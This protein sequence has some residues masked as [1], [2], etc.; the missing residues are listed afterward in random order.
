MKHYTSKR[1]HRVL[2]LM[3]SLVLLLGASPVLAAGGSG[4]D[5][6]YLMA[7]Q[8]ALHGLS[9]DGFP[10]ALA[11]TGFTKPEGA[12]YGSPDNCPKGTLSLSAVTGD[13]PQAAEAQ[14]PAGTYTV[15]F[16]DKYGGYTVGGITLDSAAQ[17]EK[18]FSV[19][20]AAGEETTLSYTLSEEAQGEADS[21][22]PFVTKISLTHGG[23]TVE[24]TGDD[25]APALENVKVG[26]AVTVKYEFLIRNPYQQGFRGDPDPENVPAYPVTIPEK[27]FSYDLSAQEIE[28]YDAS[29]Q[30][31]AILYLDAEHAKASIKFTQTI[32][33]LTASI[34]GWF[35][36]EGN[37]AA[38]EGGGSGELEFSVAGKPV[39]VIVSPEGPDKQ[40]A[41]RTD[42]SGATVNDQGMI[43]WTYTVAPAEGA[44]GFPAGLVM[45]DQ[46]TLGDTAQEIHELRRLE[47]VK[48][49]NQDGEVLTLSEVGDYTLTKGS[50]VGG[51]TV[52]LKK[53]FPEGKSL[54][55]AFTSNLSEAGYKALYGNAKNPAAKDVTVKNTVTSYNYNAEQDTPARDWGTAKAQVTHSANVFTKARIGTAHDSGGQKVLTWRLYVNRNFMQMPA[56]ATITDT[57]PEGLTYLPG[58]LKT[59]LFK[60]N[61]TGSLTELKNYD[62]VVTGDYLAE[63]D[64]LAFTLTQG[65]DR[66]LAIE[67][68]TALPEN[69]NDKQTFTNEASL[70]FW[71][72][73]VN[74]SAGS[75]EMT[76]NIVRKASV[77]LLVPIR[78]A[79]WDVYFGQTA[80]TSTLRDTFGPNQALIAGVPAL[81]EQYRDDAPVGD[82]GKTFSEF[83][84]S[85]Y[86]NTGFKPGDGKNPFAT[87]Y[88][89]RIDGSVQ[90]TKNIPQ[91]EAVALPL[92]A[93]VAVPGENGTTATANYDINSKTL[94]VAFSGPLAGTY[95]LRFWTQM[96]SNI[97]YGPVSNGNQAS[98]DNMTAY[99]PAQGVQNGVTLE[100]GG[101]T[102]TGSASASVSG[103]NANRQFDKLLKSGHGYNQ[104]NHTVTWLL[105]ANHWNLPQ[106]EFKIVD[107]LP[108]GFVLVDENLQPCGDHPEKALTVTADGDLAKGNGVT[109][110]YGKDYTV[111]F[112][113]ANLVLAF[114]GTVY[115]AVDVEVRTKIT[116]EALQQQI[117][118]ALQ[119]A[120]ASAKL[121]WR[122][123]GG[124]SG[125]DPEGVRHATGDWEEQSITVI[126]AS[127]SASYDNKDMISWTVKLNENKVEFPGTNGQ[128]I[129]DQL[130]IGNLPEGVAPSDVAEAPSDVKLKVTGRDNKSETF[131]LGMDSGAGQSWY[132]YDPDTLTIQVHLVTPYGAGQYDTN[133]YTL[134]YSTRIKVPEGLKG[135]NAIS[136]QNGVKW[137]KGGSSA[138]VKNIKIS[139]V[140]A[141]VNW[142]TMGRLTIHKYAAADGNP[143]TPDPAQPL[144][145][146]HFTVYTADGNA[147]AGGGYTGKDGTVSIVLPK[148]DYVVYEDYA[149]RGYLASE[150]SK[151]GIPVTVVPGESTDLNNTVLVANERIRGG[152]NVFKYEKA[153]DGSADTATPLPGAEFGLFPKGAA[154]DAEPLRTATTDATGLAVFPNLAF[155][156]Y[157]VRELKA[158]DGY[159]LDSQAQAQDIRDHNTFYD[160]TFV[161]EPVLGRLVVTKMS[162]KDAAGAQSLLTGAEFELLAADGATVVRAAQAVDA[163]GQVTFSGLRLGSYYLRETKAPEGYDLH[164]GLI[165]VSAVQN[166]QNNTAYYTVT[167]Q[168]T[169]TGGGGGGGGGGGNRPNRPV[170]TPEGMT[171]EEVEQLIEDGYVPLSDAPDLTPEEIIENQIPLAYMPPTAVPA[172][173]VPAATGVPRTG[174][175]APIALLLSMMLGS[176]GGMALL[177]KRR[178]RER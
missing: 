174:D 86:S 154:A 51:F 156:E 72:Y 111:A 11:L 22:D 54:T 20:V 144:S 141:A 63:G 135:V 140:E 106:T 65:I 14:V 83:Y 6:A 131:E 139:N 66:P 80:G 74:S 143:A 7:A 21:L 153:A 18:A 61:V 152:I 167:N 95:R 15:A 59:Y 133:A 5:D 168:L 116:D 64:P 41:G 160:L 35:T 48:V 36:Y 100:T 81:A 129:T 125:T 148:G 27:G 145:G 151:N 92:G 105:K 146:A 173:S 121:T 67:F 128:V 23:K 16:D 137:Y 101:K 79:G 124:Q 68:D 82:T 26:D 150:Q 58:T 4:W 114:Q 157:E 161:N 71:G 30:R 98:A 178:I 33:D 2:A 31:I 177:R 87:I 149:P 175:S 38:T 89:Q 77:S 40:A 102:Y 172:A 13:G 113:G 56:G 69:W 164:T 45:E 24:L 29:G 46:M 169:S 91:G 158:P 43:A 52:A 37:I 126:P 44:T 134:T 25:E 136:I 85:R 62:E 9:E 119:K 132:E 163:N 120:P 70:S 117:D 104:A 75:G 122:N 170:V 42:K 110:E 107:S 176:L 53:G 49:E 39:T 109:Y 1:L 76:G 97:V 3:L 19:Q 166:G 142:D 57:L 159:V 171:P 93:A 112:D 115:T 138:T 165:P 96:G 32:T 8:D 127:K 55:V 17:A 155:G 10:L 60:G 130:A 47:S 50:P 99:I 123:N 108:A 94:T 12:D 84:S 78:A 73:T 103:G 147:R 162:E 88:L 34:G 90:T 118:S 28:I